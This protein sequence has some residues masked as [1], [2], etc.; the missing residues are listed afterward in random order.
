MV[1]GVAFVVNFTGD[2]PEASK[3]LIT[4]Q[5]AGHLFDRAS[6]QGA[7]QGADQPLYRVPVQVVKEQPQEHLK[8]TTVL[9][10]KKPKNPAKEAIISKPTQQQ[11]RSARTAEPGKPKPQKSVVAPK[12]ARK[13]TAK[14]TTQK[15]T[16][17][18]TRNG[19]NAPW[20]KYAI[21]TPTIGTRPAISIVLD[22][23][24]IDQRRTG[25]AIDMPAPLTLAFIPYGYN[26]RTHTARAHASGHELLVHI[27]MEPL[28]MAANPGKNALLT[29]LTEKQLRS[30]L[31][32][33]LTRFQGYVG[34]NNH[35]GSKFTAWG[36]GMK[37]VLQTLKNR[38]LLFLDSKT[39]KDTRGYRLAKSLSVPHAVRDV[40]IDHVISEESITRQL[41]LLEKI[42][43]ERGGAIGIGH[44][45][46]ATIAALKIWI[47]AA[48]KRGIVFVPISVL[49]KR[50]FLSG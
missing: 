42:A 26:L 14:K 50:K 20:R 35:M 11:V 21:L 32:W 25:N 28:D 19:A 7:N 43:R 46:D 37:I 40:F 15:N 34:I 8:S 24:G 18:G 13:S 22:D 4:Q 5:Q 27:P 39:N 49:V 47:P 23:L 17:L 29:T 45:H 38:G 1:L 10:S 16:N 9:K 41:R 2:T 36:P 48:K 31:E 3:G 6:D 44:P 30:R 33:N 12:P